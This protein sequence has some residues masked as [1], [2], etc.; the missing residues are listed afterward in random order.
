[1]GN[2]KAFIQQHPFLVWVPLGLILFNLLVTVGFRMLFFDRI[3]L[4]W[5]KKSQLEKSVSLLEK[6]Y[7]KMRSTYQAL[8]EVKENTASFYTSIATKPQ[9][10]TRLL[11]H[12]DELTRRVNL[13][14]HALSF[15]EEEASQTKNFP[16]RTFSITF[17]VEGSYQN[18]RELLHL[19]EKSEHFIIVDKIS[20]S[21][22][23]ELGDKVRLN[24]H[25]FTVF[26]EDVKG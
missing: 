10:L 13:V 26:H 15:D 23:G 16:A 17:P 18:I 12:L 4:E 24:I 22:S 20:L 8:Q 25:L 6:R 19:L 3:R 7:K 5:N 14:P 11:A 2:L 1:M 21:Q 9:R